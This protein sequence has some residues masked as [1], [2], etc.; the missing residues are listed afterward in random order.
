MNKCDERSG[1]L[2]L[3]ETTAQIMQSIQAPNGQR[4]DLVRD[5]TYQSGLHAAKQAMRE[6]IRRESLNEPSA[7][8]TI[9][10]A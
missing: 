7:G 10:T 2:T 5:E 9:R 6:D 4:V 8:R 1:I 3:R